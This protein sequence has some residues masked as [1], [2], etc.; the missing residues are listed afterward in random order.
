MHKVDP[1]TQT[2]EDGEKSGKNHRAAIRATQFTSERSMTQ[3]V[4]AIENSNEYRDNMA[5]AVAEGKNKF[6]VENV[7]LE[8]ALGPDYLEHVRGRRVMIRLEIMLD[9]VPP[10]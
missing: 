5:K 10:F 1:I 7:S 6:V 4:K 2:K 9:I 3:A 8:S